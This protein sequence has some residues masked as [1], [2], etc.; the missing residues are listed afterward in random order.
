ML[1][2]L[3]SPQ[4]H[5]YPGNSLRCSMCHAR[6]SALCAHFAASTPTP[7]MSV[8]TA[9]VCCPAA[10]QV[11]TSLHIRALRVTAPCSRERVTA[12]AAATAPSHGHVACQEAYRSTL[13]PP[14][15]C[16]RAVAR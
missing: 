7:M 8:F 5:T 9:S 11:H 1:F 15:R 14:I 6:P 16:P 3:T 4:R 2:M 10:G 12:A 13:P